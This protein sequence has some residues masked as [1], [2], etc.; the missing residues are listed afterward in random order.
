MNCELCLSSGE[1]LLFRDEKLRV[2]LVDDADY[3]GF[4]RVI[5]HDHVKEMSDLN[6]ADRRHLFDWIMHTERAVRAVLNPDKINLASLG[7]MVPHLH[8]H[9]IPRFSDDPHFPAPIWAQARREGRRRTHSA[10]AEKLKAA[11]PA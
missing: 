9:V 7:N 1:T 11:L 10:L 8:W 5:W 2:I 3:P 6:E 4:C